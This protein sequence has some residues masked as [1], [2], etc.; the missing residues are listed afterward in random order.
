MNKNK[1]RHL[2]A[3]VEKPLLETDKKQVL[4]HIQSSQEE[5][6]SFSDLTIDFLRTKAILAAETASFYL[7]QLCGFHQQGYPSSDIS[8]LY[9]LQEQLAAIENVFVALFRIHHGFV[10]L[11]YEEFPDVLAWLYLGQQFENQDKKSTLLGISILDDL[12]T[13]LSIT[14]ILRSDSVQLDKILVRLIEGK[15]SNRD[16]YFQCV[17]LKQSVSIQLVKHWLEEKTLSQ[18]TLHSYLALSNVNSSIQWLDETK[19]YEDVL[20]EQLILKEDRATWL[21]QKS[22]PENKPSDIVCSYSKLL[23]LKEC[24]EF[25]IQ[26][27]H[28]Y[29]HLVLCGDTT[30]VP[31]VIEHLKTLDEY[32]AK[33]WYEALFILYGELLPFL[34][35]EIGV[36][37]DWK[38]AYILLLEWKEKQDIEK[39]YALRMGKPLDFDTSI[40][41]MKSSEINAVLRGWLWRELCILSRVHFYWH[42]QLPFHDQERLFEN[43]INIPLIRERF[44]LRGKNE[45][46]GY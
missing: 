2:V 25:D 22:L 6:D 46:V 21:Y 34:P 43:I 36:L 13:T 1:Y 24:S 8:Y 26:K 4:S 11:I 16:L 14:L 39:T 32:D 45:T 10:N 30:L 7:K 31:M 35:S 12:D 44:N 33:P 29:V 9:L 23:A 38:D 15:S 40:T 17:V 3:D 41:A 18:N 42:A 28:S 37:I 5:L 27:K 19:N 20:F